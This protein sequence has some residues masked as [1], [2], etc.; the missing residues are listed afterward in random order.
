MTRGKLRLRWGT[1]EVRPSFKRGGGDDEGYAKGT[2][3]V[4]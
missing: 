4:R 3:G 1:L 2:L